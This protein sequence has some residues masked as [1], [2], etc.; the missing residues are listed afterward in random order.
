MFS[1][2]E[3]RVIVT[4]GASGIGKAISLLFSKHG[5]NVHVI[6]YNETALN[7]LL[8]ESSSYSAN[9]FVHPCDVSNQK[10]VMEVLN[11]IDKVDVLI[12]NA[13]VAHIGNAHNTIEKDFNQVFNI[14]VNGVYNLLYACLPK[15]MEQ[16]NG[17]IIN[18]CSIAALVGIEDRFAYSAS[19]GAMAAMTLSVAKDYIKY[20]IRCNSISPARVHTPFVDGYISKNYPGR[21]KEMFDKLSKSQ[22]LG[23]MVHPYEVASLA[24]YLASDEARFISGNDYPLDGGFVKLNN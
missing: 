2:G 10:S 22:P 23:R 1:I 20:N 7:G 19:K 14:N 24:L 9:L 12:N 17:C 6:D 5:A 11:S 3:K 13:G 21:E 8:A 4:G 16:E 18:I 15:M